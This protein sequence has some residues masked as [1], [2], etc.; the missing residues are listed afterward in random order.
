MM[1]AIKSILRC[2]EV[3]HSVNRT[4]DLTVDSGIFYSLNESRLYP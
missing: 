1:G 3:E 2:I 4:Y